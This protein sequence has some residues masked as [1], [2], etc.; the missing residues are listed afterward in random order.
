MQREIGLFFPIM[1]RKV[2]NDL[3]FNWMIRAKTW[4]NSALPKIT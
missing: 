4:Q 3:L 1:P 2:R